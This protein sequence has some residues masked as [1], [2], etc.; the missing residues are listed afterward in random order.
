MERNCCAF[1]I[2]HWMGKLMTCWPQALVCHYLGRSWRRDPEQV[3]NG[4]TIHALGLS[5]AWIDLALSFLLLLFAFSI[6]AGCLYLTSLCA[7]LWNPKWHLGSISG[8]FQLQQWNKC[9]LII[10]FCDGVQSNSREYLQIVQSFGDSHSEFCFFSIH[11]LL[12]VGCPYGLAAGS[13]LGPYALC[14]TL[15]A[16]AEADRERSKKRGGQRALPMAVYVV[17]GD[18]DGERGGAPVLCVE[19]V[20]QLCSNWIDPTGGWSPLLVLVPLVLGLDKVN[21]RSVTLFFCS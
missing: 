17:S 9:V 6:V 10:A 21:P 2:L 4:F 1:G 14:R 3:Y 8:S 12:E 15:E 5:V 19:D 20:A 7:T 13:W 18:A 16:L 11:N